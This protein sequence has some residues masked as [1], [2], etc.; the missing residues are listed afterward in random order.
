MVKLLKSIFNFNNFRE[1]MIESFLGRVELT[2]EDFVSI[3]NI[4]KNINTN[5]LNQ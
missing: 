4:V 2:T 1:A 3:S 5:N